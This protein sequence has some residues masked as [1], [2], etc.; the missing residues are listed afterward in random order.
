MIEIF[1]FFVG[2]QLTI[3]FFASCYRIIDLWYC[4]NEHLVSILSRISINLLLIVICY[5][6]GN[7]AFNSGLIAGQIFFSFYHL[8]IFWLGQLLVILLR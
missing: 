6:L 7:E 2:V 5:L 3:N 8:C 4:L 1:G